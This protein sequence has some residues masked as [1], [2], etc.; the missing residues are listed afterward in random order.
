MKYQMRW[1][2]ANA[3]IAAAL[4]RAPDLWDA[5]RVNG[6]ILE[7]QGYYQDAIDEFLEASRLAPNMTFLNIKLGMSY[8]SLAL[9]TNS[10]VLYDQAIEQFALAAAVNEQLGI[11]SSMPYLGIGRTYAQIGESLA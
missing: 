5:H 10:D 11:Q 2:K 4:E 1:D 7:S 9:K 6:L 3:S 8:R